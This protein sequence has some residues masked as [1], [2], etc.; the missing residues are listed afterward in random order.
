M[1]YLV[2]STTKSS[3]ITITISGSYSSAYPSSSFHISSPSTATPSLLSLPPSSPSSVAISSL[4]P[5][6]NTSPPPKA[7]SS[8][9]G[10]TS[11][12]PSGPSQG[13]TVTYVVN[14]IV[15]TISVLLDNMASAVTKLAPYLV[16]F[17]A[18]FSILCH[19]YNA[20]EGVVLRFFGG[21][22]RI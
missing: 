11:C 8:S 1:S 18:A 15:C 12:P 4:P 7:S 17:L 19:T 13:V 22:F 9:S 5:P 20:V 14:D 16:S 6:P 3:G 10:A 2:G 21:Y